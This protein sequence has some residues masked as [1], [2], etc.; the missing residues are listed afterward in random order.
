MNDRINSLTTKSTAQ[1]KTIT[2][3]KQQLDSTRGEIIKINQ[4][5]E[6]NLE[7]VQKDI[8]N[9]RTQLKK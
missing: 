5:R 8:E 7:T 3:Y 6:E 4:L 2:T 1:D 9:V